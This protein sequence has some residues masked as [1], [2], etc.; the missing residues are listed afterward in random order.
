M[1]EK[2]ILTAKW[3][4]KDLLSFIFINWTIYR[5]TS[6]R[7]LVFSWFTHNK[8]TES[9]KQTQEQMPGHLSVCSLLKLLHSG[10]LTVS[11]LAS[12]PTL[13]WRGQ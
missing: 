5:L 7:Y 4:E 13:A 8:Q 3:E 2:T 6:G 11:G 1:T 9:Q 12:V 10:Q